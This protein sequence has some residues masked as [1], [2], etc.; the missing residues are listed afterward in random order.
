MIWRII[1]QAR[2]QTMLS[3]MLTG[4][5]LFNNSGINELLT[6]TKNPGRLRRD[7]AR[8]E[9]CRPGDKK[10]NSGSAQAA[11]QTKPSPGTLT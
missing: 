1:E 8:P 10:R 4:K 9:P 3:T 7:K 2:Q 5:G 11:A 6:I